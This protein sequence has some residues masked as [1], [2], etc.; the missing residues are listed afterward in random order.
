MIYYS[1]NDYTLDN[2]ILQHE[3]QFTRE[4]IKEMFKEFQASDYYHK[5]FGGY[6]YW[7][8]KFLTSEKGFDIINTDLDNQF[9]VD[10]IRNQV[11]HVIL[12]ENLSR[13]KKNGN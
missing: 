1:F 4:D 12:E 5:R 8:C 11:S 7:F 10:D 13:G 2:F 9:D 3:N 6:A